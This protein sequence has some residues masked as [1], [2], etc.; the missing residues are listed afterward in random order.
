VLEDNMPAPKG[1]APYAGCEKGALFGYLGKPQDAYTEEEIRKI[2]MELL[3]WF[4]ENPMEIW[5]KDFCAYR[6]IKKSTLNWFL[7]N[8]PYFSEYYEQAQAIQEG[9]ILKYSLFKKSDWN[10]GKFIL[11]RTHDEYKDIDASDKNTAIA[12]A[13]AT[14][15]NFISD[16]IKKRTAINVGNSTGH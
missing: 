11:H 8:Y 4:A 16:E 3:E 10:V 6:G 15:A 13:A 7:K 5:V 1:H 2:G 9:R 12:A 14:A